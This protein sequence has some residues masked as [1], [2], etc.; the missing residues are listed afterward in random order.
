MY[1]TTALFGN[2][3]ITPGVTAQN[4]SEGG[5]SEGFGT[6]DP[7]RLLSSTRS[8]NAIMQLGDLNKKL[9]ILSRLPHLGPD[10]LFIN[11]VNP[12]SARHQLTSPSNT[13]YIQFYQSGYRISAM[14]R[15]QGLQ[16]SPHR[17]VGNV[18]CHY[19]HF[20]GNALMLTGRLITIGPP[21]SVLG[22]AGI[23]VPVPV[24]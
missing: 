13:G 23:L 16:V 22:F 12:T 4:Q 18:V 19:L 5:N 8:I 6:N 10:Y 9:R 7:T 14:R 3:F 24:H 1:S 11:V 20:R 17:F 2:F 15:S 21:V